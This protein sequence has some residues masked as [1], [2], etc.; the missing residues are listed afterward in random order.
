[1]QRQELNAL[2]TAWPDLAEFET[3]TFM[4]LSA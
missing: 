1:M 4:I 2:F 3:N